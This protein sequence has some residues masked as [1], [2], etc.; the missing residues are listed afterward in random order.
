ME[1]FHSQISNTTFHNNFP[2]QYVCVR[3]LLLL[4][5]LF[6]ILCL[7]FEPRTLCIL[8]KQSTTQLHPQPRV[9][10]LLSMYWLL[11]EVALVVH[12]CSDL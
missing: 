12:R 1:I 2:Q 7:G 9:S 10:L 8:V 4:L 11:Q 6:F 3:L 5:L